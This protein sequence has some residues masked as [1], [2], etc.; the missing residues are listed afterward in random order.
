M[1]NKI[2]AKNNAEMKIRG[3]SFGNFS[4][5][6]EKFTNMNQI[7]KKERKERGRERE[8]NLKIDGRNQ[9]YA[10]LFFVSTVSKFWLKYCVIQ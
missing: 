8:K 4:F 10:K 9:F 5:L 2:L 6:C 7:E 1:K 3:I